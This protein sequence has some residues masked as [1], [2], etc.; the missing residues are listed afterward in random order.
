MLLQRCPNGNYEERCHV[1][2]FTL[3]RLL[4][5]EAVWKLG[6]YEI[7]ENDFPRV[8]LHAKPSGTFSLHSCDERMLSRATCRPTEF[9]HSLGRPP[10]AS[11]C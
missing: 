4:G 1:T 8:S 10:S 9:S 3:Q 6:T 11:A 7:A 2:R 5:A